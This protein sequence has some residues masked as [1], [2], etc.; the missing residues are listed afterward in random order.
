MLPTLNTRYT[1]MLRRSIFNPL[2]AKVVAGASYTAIMQNYLTRLAAEGGSLTNAEKG[3]LNTLTLNPDITEFDRLW[4]HGL[5][6]QIAARISLVNALTAD[7]I[8]NVNSTTFTAGQGFTGNGTTMYLD[9]NYNPVVD[10]V[11]YLQDSSSFGS[12]FKTPLQSGKL[13]GVLIGLTGSYI[14]DNTISIT[15]ANNDNNDDSSNF[16][17]NKDGLIITT[18]DNSANKN[19]WIDGVESTDMA[20]A[21]NGVPNGNFYLLA[22]NLN[23]TAI[24]FG[25]QTIS[26]SFIGSGAI[27]QAQ[28]YTDVQALGTSLGWAV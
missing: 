25:N 3:Y 16:T 26:A 10:G 23:G 28:F 11:K 20:R 14:Y 17:T 8:T 27:D 6:N 24:S 5:S 13:Q 15:A 1:K 12:Y 22:W 21:S 2:L 9:T 4:V 18:R 19:I 7:L